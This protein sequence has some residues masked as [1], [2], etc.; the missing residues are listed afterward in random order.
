MNY[1]QDRIRD[2]KKGNVRHDNYIVCMKLVDKKKKE[3]IYIEMK[4]SK[5]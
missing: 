3:S 4:N 5:K 2:I 1:E